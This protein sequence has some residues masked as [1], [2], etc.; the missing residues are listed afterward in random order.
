MLHRINLIVSFR[1]HLHS[2]ID[3]PTVITQGPPV[4]TIRTIFYG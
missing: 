2:V 1:Y 4:P 3:P